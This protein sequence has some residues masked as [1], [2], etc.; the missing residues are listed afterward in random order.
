MVEEADA[1]VQGESL[2]ASATL[3]CEVFQLPDHQV[4]GNMKAFAV[5]AAALFAASYAH[6]DQSCHFKSKWAVVCE[7]GH[8]AVD[9]FDIYGFDSDRMAQSYSRAAL[10]EAGCF[11][12]A[13]GVRI[14]QFNHGRVAYTNGWASVT[15]IEIN[16]KY[17]GIVADQYI[18]GRCEKYVPD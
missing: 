10:H 3:L 5:V 4:E 16:G 9:A 11:L 18:E 6:A 15:T 17:S 7:T 13:N 12:A 2:K 8:N 14:K 1:Y